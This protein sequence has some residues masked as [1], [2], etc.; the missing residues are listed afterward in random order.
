MMAGTSGIVSGI[1][2]ERIIDYVHTKPPE[3]SV[4]ASWEITYSANTVVAVMLRVLNRT[5]GMRKKWDKIA[6]QE[7]ESMD[8]GAQKD[9]G[10][11]RQRVERH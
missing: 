4:A 3:W 5:L 6:K 11:L 7:F 1:F 2:T 10:E 8:S 9:W